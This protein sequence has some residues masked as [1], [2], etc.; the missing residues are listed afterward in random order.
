MKLAKDSIITLSTRLLIVVFNLF[1]LMVTTRILGSEGRGIYAMVILVVTV[2][3]NFS[4]L[5]IE[6]GNVYFMGKNR[7]PAEKLAANSLCFSLGL[8]FVTI[9]VF[10]ILTD[11]FDTSIVDGFHEAIAVIKE[12]SATFGDFFDRFIVTF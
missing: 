4:G 8:G 6:I 11:F 7:I 12:I 10:F 5:G 1:I 2:L 9:F 3:R